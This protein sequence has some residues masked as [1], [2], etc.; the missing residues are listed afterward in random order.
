MRTGFLLL[1]LTLPLAAQRTLLQEFADPPADARIMMRWWWF[2]PAV[3]N[4]EL[5]RELRVMKDAGIGGVEVQPVYPIA[6]DDQTIHNEPYL[7]PKFL[8][9]LHFAAA[10]AKSLGLRFDL[11]LGSGWPYGGP[12]IPASLAA[13]R[14]RVD[15]SAMPPSLAGGEK[16]VGDTSNDDGTHT[17]YISSRTGQQVK[18]AGV[19]AEGFVLDHYDRAAID[20]HLKVAGERLLSA[21]GVNSPYSVFCDS[22]EVYGSDWTPD[23]LDEFSRRRGYDLRPHLAELVSGAGSDAK[24]I[25]N[26]W[27][28]TLT[29]LLDDHFFA[30]LHAWAAAHHTKLRAQAYGTPPAS[31]STMSRVDLPEGEGIQW[32]TLSQLRYATS[33]AHVLGRNVV[34]SE[35]WTWLHSPVFRATPVDL[36]AEANLHFLQGVNQLVGH[37]WPYS[38]PSAEYPGWRFYASGVW[39]DKNPWFI[40]MPEIAAYF[41]SVSNMLRQG[42]PVSDVALYMPNSDAWGRFSPG[43]VDLRAALADH[44]GPDLIPAILEAGYGF[45]A[46]DDGVLA[47]AEIAG[48]KLTMGGVAYPVVVLPSVETMPLDTARKLD[49]F[50]QAG[51]AVIATNRLPDKAPGFRATPGEHD[52]VRKIAA[53]WTLVRDSELASRLASIVPPDV[54]LTDASG[55]RDVGFVHRRTPSADIYFVANT[56]NQTRK[57]QVKF[58]G[59]GMPGTVWDPLSMPKDAATADLTLEPFGSRFIVFSKSVPVP[60]PVVAK[61]PADIDLSQNWRVTFAKSPAVE[62]PKLEP[63]SDLNYSGIAT[64]ERDVETTPEWPMNTYLDFGDGHAVERTPGM[65][66]QAQYEGPVREAAVVYVNGKRAGA[67]W[68]PPYRLNVGSLLR[69][70]KNSLKIVVGNLAVNYM[71][72]HRQPDYKLLNLRYTERFTPQDMDKIQPVPSGLLGPIHLTADRRR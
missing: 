64:Y 8:D 44:I 70:G 23:F 65:G 7:S 25:R 68:C 29:E 28:R 13:G 37:G 59:Q 72:G 1:C 33:A 17:Y 46:F 24:A 48:G 22:L 50:V 71:A 38:A 62:M 51:G 60:E 35:T 55:A 63:W 15:K 39:S 19:S 5:A 18:R 61:S 42:K 31:I 66:Y 56:G 45:D 32:K 54:T 11:T 36:K 3:T 20:L 53:R 43:K 12:H 52:E 69:P 6:V 27:G 41:Q 40:A 9:S 58:R 16:I 21:L 4:A 57:V 10:T 34:S 2:G 47:G 14:L 49:R 30:P 67:V 26:D